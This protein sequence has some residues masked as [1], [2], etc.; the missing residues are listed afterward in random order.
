MSVFSS[1]LPLAV[2]ARVAR[3]GNERKATSMPTGSS[4][5]LRKVGLSLAFV[6]GFLCD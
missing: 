3:A 1:Q 2:L 6:T 4:L 5:A